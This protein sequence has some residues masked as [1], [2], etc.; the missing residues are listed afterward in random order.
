MKPSLLRIAG[1]LTLAA[2]L[3]ASPGSAQRPAA[4]PLKGSA[5]PAPF[6]PKFE[7]LAET[8]LLM[9]G[10]AHSNYRS[11]SRQLRNRAPDGETWVF[12]RGQSLLIAETG[13][14]LL[15]RPPRNNGRDTWMKLSMELRDAAGTLARAAGTRDLTRSRTALDGVTNA[16]NRCHTTF[17]IPVRIGPEEDARPDAVSVE[18]RE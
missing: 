2:L 13:N 5:V 10:L 1:L 7:A 14:L 12:V 16:C 8:R 9:E 15:L 3:L 11:I 4:P 18:V 17:R 6:T